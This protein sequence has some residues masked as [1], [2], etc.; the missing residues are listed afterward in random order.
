MKK[1]MR[2]Q[3]MQN[4]IHL[5]PRRDSSQSQKVPDIAATVSAGKLTCCNRHREGCG[6]VGVGPAA[7]TRTGDG[8]VVVSAC[9]GTHQM[10]GKN[11]P[12][13]ELQD[14]SQEQLR[15]EH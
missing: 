12:A 9:D 14:A 2:A 3:G 11:G 13:Q 5:P 4:T 1:Y 8:F 6:G 7:G 15:A 10:R